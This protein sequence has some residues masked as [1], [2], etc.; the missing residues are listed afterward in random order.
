MNAERRRAARLSR[1]RREGA[2]A[3]RRVRRQR[4]SR[5]ATCRST[6]PPPTPTASTSRS[7]TR[8][9][10]SRTPA[11]RRSKDISG[12]RAARHLEVGGL[13]R[14]RVRRIAAALFGR[15]GRVLRRRSTPAI[16]RRSRRAPAR[17]GIWSSTATRCVNAARRVPL[18]DGWTL[19]VWSRNLLNKDYFELLT[20]A[21]GNTGLYVGQPGD[22]RTV[23]VTLRMTLRSRT[24]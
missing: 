20:A 11:V 12:S 13:G 10:R 16:A 6:A 4:A 21:P 19:S 22:P 2:R 18:A 5:A 9:R 7:P 17:R 24:P 14:R 15:A 23:G 1:Q 3:R 8:R